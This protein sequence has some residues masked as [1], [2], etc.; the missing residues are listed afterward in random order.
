MALAYHA[1]TDQN[2]GPAW[3]NSMA[4]PK[5]ELKGYSDFHTGMLSQ[6]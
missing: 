1:A 3:A 4:M 2:S 5:T 6:Y